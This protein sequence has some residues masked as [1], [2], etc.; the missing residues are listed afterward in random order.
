MRKFLFISLCITILGF[1]CSLPVNAQELNRKIGDG[2]TTDGIHY[3]VYEAET[4]QIHTRSVDSSVYVS[5]YF[6]FD[7]THFPPQKMQ[8]IEKINGFYYIGTLTRF[9][10]ISDDNQVIGNY[11][12]T[13]YRTTTY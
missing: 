2:Y 12:G 5:R 7:S 1:F 6:V 8:Y 10:V 3:T 11:R 4:T 9:S 13:L